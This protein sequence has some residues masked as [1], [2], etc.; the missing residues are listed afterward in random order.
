KPD[1]ARRK[2]QMCSGADRN[3][4]GQTLDNAKD[5]GLK[6]SHEVFRF[7][8]LVFCALSLELCALSLFPELNWRRKAISTQKSEEQSSKYKVQV[9]F[10]L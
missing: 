9:R 3:E 7:P 2:N 6:K 5:D 4:F 10:I 8:S 1:R